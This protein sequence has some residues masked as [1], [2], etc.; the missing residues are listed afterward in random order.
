MRVDEA[1]V[2]LF[3]EKYLDTD[4]IGS[5][6]RTPFVTKPVSPSIVIMRNCKKCFFRLLSAVFTKFSIFF[7]HFF[8]FSLL[9]L[10]CR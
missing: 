9:L 8:H 6:L 4:G 5:K 10:V 1:E 3:I 7:I 2:S